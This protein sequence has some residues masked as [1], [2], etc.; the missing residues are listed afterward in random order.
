MRI[1]FVTRWESND[2]HAWSGTPYHMAEAMKSY[3]H[4]IEFIGPLTIPMEWGHKL[5]RRLMRIVNRHYDF[6]RHPAVARAYA[7]QVDHALKHGKFD[8]VFSPTS[9]PL[10]YLK[11]KIP[12]VLWTDATFAAM[13]EY[14][15]GNWSRLSQISLRQGNSLEM[16]GLRNADLAVYSSDWA[17]ASAINDYGAS[18]G[19]VAV[20]PFGANLE[21]PPSIGVVEQAIATRT[22]LAC[23]LLFLGVDWNRKD[24][25]TVVRTAIELRRRGL[26]V[27]VDVVGCEPPHNVP[28]FV[29]RHGFV[30]KATSE[31]RAY[32]E[33]LLLKAHFLFVPTRAE[34]Y[35]LVFAEA[36]AYGVPSVARAVGGVPTVI[37]EGV[38]GH[39][40]PLEATPGEFAELIQ[41]LFVDERFYNSAAYRARADFDTRLNW[42]SA[43]DALTRQ[44]ESLIE[45]SGST[46]NGP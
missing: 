32:L 40:L 33:Q 46:G 18:T 9:I 39:T 38:T 14:Y 4:H 20:I 12:K 15:P 13:V 29:H 10:A 45:P 41:A 3:G 16:R 27:I 44:F 43:I 17:A 5:L 25:D 8:I 37:K 21:N 19:R 6:E 34:C 2:V 28:D 36:A 1:A 30:S 7:G 22:R 31:S 42:N 24:G 26:D 35:G 11:T 23:H